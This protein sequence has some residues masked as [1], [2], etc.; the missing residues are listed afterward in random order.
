MSQPWLSCRRYLF[1][2]VAR[3]PNAKTNYP[4]IGALT[5]HGLGGQD[6]RTPRARRPHGAWSIRPMYKLHYR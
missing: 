1:D 2:V 5:I 6:A 3:A 4:S